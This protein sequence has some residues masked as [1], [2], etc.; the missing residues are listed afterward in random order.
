MWEEERGSDSMVEV[1][2]KPRAVGDL[3]KAHNLP[4]D[5]DDANA[6]LIPD[7][8]GGHTACPN[9]S[10]EVNGLDHIALWVF[11]AEGYVRWLDPQKEIGRAHV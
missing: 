5:R 11:T 7:F 6:A 1:T 8:I 10:M 3:L 4:K 2:L 9:L